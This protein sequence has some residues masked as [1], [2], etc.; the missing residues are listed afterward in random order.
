MGGLA[1]SAT[2][3]KASS[4]THRAIQRELLTAGRVLTPLLSPSLLGSDDA[5]LIYFRVWFPG[6]QL[7]RA[8]LAKCTWQHISSALLSEP[9]L[10]RFHR[11]VPIAAAPDDQ[12]V[13]LTVAAPEGHKVNILVRLEDSVACVEV[14]AAQAGAQV[15]SWAA[16]QLASPPFRVDCAF[17][18]FP[19]NGDSCLVVPSSAHLVPE[20]LDVS[21]ASFFFR[22]HPQFRGLET[23]VFPLIQPEQPHLWLHRVAGVSAKDTVLDLLN[24]IQPTDA[25]PVTIV[26]LP[27]AEFGVLHPLAA[28]RGCL[29]TVVW[30]CD[31]HD[32]A[33]LG[34]ACCQRYL[35]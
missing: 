26:D 35:F 7:H 29:C 11:L 27:H 23:Q 25:A 3:L 32:P 5:R 20:V 30:L 17:S 1:R 16:G 8:F 28:P 14:D 31:D 21:V 34:I 19:R 18:G 4:T 24:Q 10:A 22:P 12:C 15:L 13:H 6:G 2:P 9:S 33:Q